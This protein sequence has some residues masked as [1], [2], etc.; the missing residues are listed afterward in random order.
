[1]TDFFAQL[2]A[3]HTGSADVLQPRV[4][5]RF[6]PLV[7]PTSA[8]AGAEPVGLVPT[9]WA[10]EETLPGQPPHPRARRSMPGAA[11]PARDIAT[12]GQPHG[13][14][15]AESLAGPVAGAW[16][17]TPAAPPGRTS[18]QAGDSSPAVPPGKAPATEELAALARPG[19]AIERTSAG[20]S[21]EGALGDP[22]GA[23]PRPEQAV[24][25]R[26]PGR[27][28]GGEA[29]PATAPGVTGEP[30]AAVTR[31]AYSRPALALHS[32]Q[33]ALA[34]EQDQPASSAGGRM[35]RDGT[36]TSTDAHP[37]LPVDLPVPVPLL[38]PPAAARA[39]RRA[40]QAAAPATPLRRGARAS[41]QQ[42]PGEAEPTLDGGEP[43]TVQVTIG[44]VEVRA[45]APV[46]HQDSRRPAPTGPTLAD[47]LR[48]RSR[49]A[50]GER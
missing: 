25:A 43:I 14:A 11:R 19:R 33:A 31:L 29:V 1:M 5:F 8:T 10:Q 32:M 44:R 41:M 50:G 2:T 28:T 48:R 3:R 34:A 7:Q 18:A 21:R 24:G 38:V 45:A 23:V 35:A 40:G 47:Y 13:R 49:S 9:H 4:P 6:E 46:P 15:A 27:R 17:R 16:D 39:G 26:Q 12:S 30:G 42:I 37:A 20:Q 36:P 22:S